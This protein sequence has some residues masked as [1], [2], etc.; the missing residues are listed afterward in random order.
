MDMGRSSNVARGRRGEALAANALEAKG[1]T[2]VERNWRCPAGEIDVI[3]QQGDTL[4][5]VEV[6]TR[7]GDR[8]GAPE[9]AVDDV[10]Q[11]RLLAAAL[12]YLAESDAGDVAWR[13]DVIGIDL[14]PS[15]RVQRLSHYVDAVRFDG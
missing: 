10:K 7:Q 1:Y 9:E 13:I 3:A 2:I 15:G 6:K 5:F 14:A 11:E 8:F 12:A 4:V